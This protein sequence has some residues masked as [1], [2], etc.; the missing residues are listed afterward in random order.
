MVMRCSVNNKWTQHNIMFCNH[1]VNYNLFGRKKG[2]VVYTSREEEKNLFLPIK[3]IC[4]IY[5]AHMCIHVASIITLSF[6]QS[7]WNINI[8]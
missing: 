2:K 7:L 6:A 5:G 4:M 3:N 1:T 8:T